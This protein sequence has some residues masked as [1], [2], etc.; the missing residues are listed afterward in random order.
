MTTYSLVVVG[1]SWGGLHAIST[2]VSGLPAGFPCAVAVVQ[3][4]SRDSGAV[5]ADIIQDA[6]LLPVMEVD[7]K[8]PL[9]P[10]H[11]YLAPPDYHMLVE[12]GHFSL[13]TDAPQRYSRPSIDVTFDSAADAYPGATIGVVL[14]GA[15]QDGAEGLRRIVDRGGKAI[16]Q[17]PAS[18]ASKT[19]P[20]AALDAV[21]EATVLPLEQIAAALVRLTRPAIRPRSRETT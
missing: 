20:Q 6:S 3:H 7:D 11:V 8:Q 18:A 17:E 14:T 1:A 21:K 2:L 15:N 4:R 9:E 5:L 13:T 10:G 16:I 12:R 19:M